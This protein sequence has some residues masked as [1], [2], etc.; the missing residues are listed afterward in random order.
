MKWLILIFV[1][2]MGYAIFTN[3]MGGA[4]KA[5]SN[6]NKLLGKQPVADPKYAKEK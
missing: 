5:A 6:Y 2:G 3:N 1:L 4:R